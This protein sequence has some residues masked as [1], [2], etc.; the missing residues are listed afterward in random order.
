MRE[1]HDATQ[2]LGEKF[3]EWCAAM[4]I[5]RQPSLSITNQTYQDNV[6]EMHF[7]TMVDDVPFSGRYVRGE[8]LRMMHGCLPDW[9][10]GRGHCH[11]RR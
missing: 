11:R 3:A 9:C 4:G 10:P 6:P 2:E 7:T 8:K 1:I 5:E